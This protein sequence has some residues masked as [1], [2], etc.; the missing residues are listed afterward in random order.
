[1][2]LSKKFIAGTVLTGVLAMAYPGSVQGGDL[3]PDSKKIKPL[4][5][6]SVDVGRKHVLSF[7]LKKDGLCD[8]TMMVTDRPTKETEGDEIPA[9][10][11]AKFKAEITGGGVATVGFDA[12]AGAVL[13]YECA[14]GAQ[15]MSIRELYP[16]AKTAPGP[17]YPYRFNKTT[18]AAVGG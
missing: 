14:P 1:M 9:L 6:A 7:F 4:Y 12:D 16:V 2:Y 17:L 3:F 8:V 18:V 15:A 10:S 5:A 13:E 11:T